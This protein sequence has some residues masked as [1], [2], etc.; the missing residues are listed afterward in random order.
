MKLNKILTGV[1]AL[2]L[3][4][5]TL[6][7]SAQERFRYISLTNTAI[8]TAYAPVGTN[9]SSLTNSQ[10]YAPATATVFFIGDL[11]NT[12]VQ[13]EQVVTSLT[14]GA[15]TSTCGLDL[16]PDGT[17]WISNA[18]MASVGGQGYGT[19]LF[20]TYFPL[21]NGTNVFSGNSYAR[22]A[23]GNAGQWTNMT[24]LVNRLINYR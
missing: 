13:W 18:V 7:A 23:Y 15:S 12:P 1:A 8:P 14:N 22:W 20:T 16:S 11:Q 17:Y 24:W 2:G 10:V 9:T 6:T 5:I 4:M 21:S 19:N 3:A